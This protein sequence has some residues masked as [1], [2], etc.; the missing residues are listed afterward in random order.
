MRTVTAATVDIG[1]QGHL[2]DLLPAELR[3]AVRSIVTSIAITRHARMRMSQRGI[4]GADIEVLLVHA[5]DIGD[6]RL[7]LRDRDAN[8]M[9]ERCRRAIRIVKRQKTMRNTNATL[10]TLRGAISTFERLRGKVLVTCEGSLVTAYHQS[11]PIRSRFRKARARR[12]NRA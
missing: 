6:D 4:H 8:R 1:N 9:I 5:T 2:L 12:H 3:E 10:R 7:M 11:E